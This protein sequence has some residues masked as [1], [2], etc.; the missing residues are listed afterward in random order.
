MNNLDLPGLLGH[1]SCPDLPG[2]L[3]LVALDKPAGVAQLADRLSF[4][5]LDTVNTVGITGIAVRIGVASLVSVVVAVSVGGRVS[6]DR[7]T[8]CGRAYTSSF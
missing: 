6:Y 2:L 7:R 8:N 4:A 1:S 5:D 3:V